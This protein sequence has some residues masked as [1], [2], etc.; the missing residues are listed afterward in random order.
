MREALK[1][2]EK[3]FVDL[4]IQYDQTTLAKFETYMQLVLEWNEKVNLTSITDEREF[5][6]KHFVD[7]LM[8]VSH[9]S[10]SSASKII[11][12]GTGAGF[13][14]IPLALIYPDKKFML[15]DSVNKKLI[16]VKEIMGKLNIRNATVVHGR[17]EDLGHQKQ[18]REQYDIC[19]S[20]AVAKL[21][22]LSEY[23]LPFVKPGGYFIAYKGSEVEQEIT[24]SQ[25]AIDVL[26]G[27]IEEIAPFKID[28]L[29]MGHNLIYIRK[30]AETPQ[31]YPRKPGTPQKEPI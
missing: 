9:K 20:R 6:I 4:E 11:D 31:K 12:I 2:L 16:I 14:G 8:C 15:M 17:A 19:V 21:Q 10:L 30:N 23:C 13:P 22:V 25:K 24:D 26:G 3:A 7:S 29:K 18:H 28:D 27:E 1:L 5:V